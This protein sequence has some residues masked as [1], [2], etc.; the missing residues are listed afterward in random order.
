MH[1]KSSWNAAK[2]KNKYVYEFKLLTYLSLFVP[3]AFCKH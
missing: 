3:F 1:H 2:Q